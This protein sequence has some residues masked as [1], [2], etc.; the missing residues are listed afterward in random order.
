MAVGIKVQKDYYLT[1]VSIE[2]PT[3]VSQVDE[4]L[5]ATKTNGKMVIQ[6]NQDNI[7]G[8][9]VEQR[10]KISESQA[11]EIRALLGIGEKIL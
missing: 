10:T 11:N 7:Q 6:Y 8:V 1:E 9:N 3:N 5:K 2:L 4:V